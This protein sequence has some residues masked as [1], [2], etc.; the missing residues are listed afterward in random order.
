MHVSD[1][2][3]PSF[4]EN[5]G[6]IADTRKHLVLLTAAE[7]DSF[8]RYFRCFGGTMFSFFAFASSR[9]ESSA[10]RM[11]DLQMQ[12]NEKVSEIHIL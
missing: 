1:R 8:S 4:Q 2:S 10:A 12:V 6:C 3:A 7:Y 5:G 9:A 11:C